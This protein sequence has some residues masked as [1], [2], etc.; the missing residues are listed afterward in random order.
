MNTIKNRRDFL[1]GGSA[2]LAGA[3]LINHNAAA[4][5]QEKTTVKPAWDQIARIQNDRTTGFSHSGWPMD[6]D[7]TLPQLRANSSITVADLAGPAVVTM[8]HVTQL[9]YFATL[10][11]S[12]EG[13]AAARAAS[14]ENATARRQAIAAGQTPPAPLV[15]PDLVP[16]EVKAR[17]VILEVYY[18]GMD[19][20]AVRVPLADFF[21][22]GCNGQAVNFSTQFVEKAPDSYNS[23]IPMPFRKSVKVVLVNETS[24]D[25]AVYAY[26]EYENLPEWDPQLGYFH[27]SWERKTWQLDDRS[28]QLLFK[29]KGKGHLLGR[30]VSIITDE[31]VFKNFAYVMEGNNEFYIDGEKEP[32]I[33]YLGSEDAFGFSWGFPE[34]HNGNF[35]GI[36]YK[37]EAD[38]AMASFYR[39]HGNQPVRFN[40]GLEIRLNHSQEWAIQNFMLNGA[41]PMWADAGRLWVDYALTHYWYQQEPGF[42]HSPL[43]PLEDRQRALLKKNPN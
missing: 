17:G 18:D 6:A 11:A 26:V 7:P 36:N 29:V 38:P 32:R 1:I 9:R 39:F 30:H 22:D 25:L 34:L 13:I 19:S 4:A 8:L 27:A 14:I 28:N 40:T 5:E 43:L 10:P 42:D 41:L 15:S 16:D 37:Q 35:H 31:T 20:P 12:P 2:G 24:L 33:N 21:A 3:T 23:F